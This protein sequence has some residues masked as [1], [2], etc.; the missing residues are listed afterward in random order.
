M[1]SKIHHL[2]YLY[3]PRIWIITAFLL[4][5]ASATAQETPP[6]GDFTVGSPIKNKLIDYPDLLTPFEE[7]GF[8]TIWQRADNY[9][10]SSLEH[11]NLIALNEY[12]SAE[13][14]FHYSTAYYSKWEAEIDAEAERVGFKH[15]DSLGNLI[16]SSSTWNGKSCWS[17]IGLSGPRDSLIYGPHYRQEKRYKRWLYGCISDSGCLTYTP[18][19]RM[20]LDNNGG[21]DS[22]E[23]V[24][25]IKVV[26]RYKEDSAPYNFHD[27]TFI[28]RTLKVG[29]FNLNGNFDD[30]YLHPDQSLGRYDYW[31]EFILPD[32]FMQ[33]V[34]SPLDLGYIDW[35]SF[36]GIQFWVDWLRTDS[37]C[38]LYIDYAEVYDNNGWNEYIDPLT[39]NDVMDS[40]KAYAESFS[41]WNNLIYWTGP[42]EPYTIDS[43]LPIHIVDSLIRSVQAPPLVV[44][45]DPSWHWTNK[46]NGEDEIEMF[47]SIAKPEK[48]ILGMYPASPNWSAI[49]AADYEW[50]RFNF[51]RTWVHD[52]NFW[53][54]P[55]AFG[56]WSN[57][58]WCV[59]RKPKSPELTS[60]V[61]LAL[62]HGSKGI[63]FEWFDSFPEYNLYEP[64]PNTYLKCLVDL[65]GNPEI[66][67]IDQDT[68]YNT[69]KNKLVPRLKDKLGKTL[70]SLNYSG[71]YLQYRYQIP[72]DN[73]EPVESNY[74]ILG[75]GTQAMDERNWHCGFF[76]R[77]THP[78]D[79]YFMLANLYLT[80]DSMTVRVKVTPPVPN[81][82]NYRFRNIEGYFDET[83]KTNII[84]DLTHLKGEGYLYQVA[85]VIQYGGKLIYPDT[86]ENGMILND[87]MIIENGAELTIDGTYFAKGNITIKSGGIINGSNGKIQFVDGKKLIIEGTGSITGTANSKLH[88]EFSDPINDDPTGILIKA[89]SSLTI[90]N[91][92]IENATTGINSL[93]NANYLNAQNVEFINCET[94][95][96][97]IAGRNP[98]MNPT[99]PP[100][101]TGCTMLNSNYGI[102]ISNLPGMLIIDNDIT[103]TTCGIY[104]SSVADAQVI[105]NTI[106]SN[107][108]EYPGMWIFSSGGAIRANYISGH[109]NGVHFANS[110]MVLG[111]NYITENKFHGLLIGDGSLPYMRQGQW[112]GIPPNM[113]ATSG[114]NKIFQNGG[115]EGEGD[116]NDGSEIYFVNSNAEMD[117]GCNSIY[118]D[119][120]PSPPLVNTELL[121]NCPDWSPIEVDAR[122]NYW[123]SWVDERRFGWLNVNYI[124]YSETPCPEPQDGSEGELVR[125]TSFGDV[126]D[127]V[128]A[129]DIEIPDLTETEEA[130][131]EAEEYFLTGNLTNALQIFEEIINSTASEEEKYPAYQRKYSIG[132]LTGQST[133]YFNQLSNTFATLSSNT[134]D[135]LNKKIL[136]QFSTL[137]KVGEQEYETAIGEFDG[138][139]QQNP[140]T[141]EAVYAEIDALTT[142]LLIE[143][144]DSTL[145]KGRLGKYLIKSSANYH[146]RVDEILRKNFGSGSKETEKELLPT[147][148][149]L[150]Q[151]YPNPFNPVTTIKYDL[152]NTSEVTLI[153]YDILGRKIKELVNT[154]QQAGRYEV[155]FDASNLA[156]GVYIYQLIA[157]NY[158]QSRKMILLK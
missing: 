66:S 103:N 117:K 104:L 27:I 3:Y 4:F 91:C 85:P 90:S 68:L 36:T 53:F 118:D 37:R 78:E 139:V 16:G 18:R 122:G 7:A 2:Y 40:I 137:S 99:P 135:T 17:S 120:E 146:Q 21:A 24:C 75:Y 49:R 143:E 33:S 92:K 13:Y 45:F 1:K 131:A 102:A 30:F 132:K 14:I 133:E 121:M 35:E 23:D 141:E 11:Y 157:E 145:Q 54:K 149:T 41:G 38:T 126:I 140:N 130:Y 158:I 128:Y 19:F 111:S 63:L 20:A 87:D 123:G 74:L 48:I 46:I 39:H 110:A 138:I 152:P 64:C 106:I 42:D 101:I 80:A 26:F 142:A 127:T 8:N 156:S 51:Q 60:M 154:K 84:K 94:H 71:D 151:N 144:A 31:P 10:Q 82:Q 25:R 56:L 124:P 67:E 119:R 93:V 69:V 136:S 22:T 114:Y 43:Y 15:R 125:M 89:N 98:G 134:Q 112:V 73:P 115:Y 72:T 59:W 95:S 88:L 113:Y 108:E 148:Y 29:D 62:A 96:I 58:A 107:R 61:M 28:E 32:N 147:E 55:Q 5:S 70:M 65:E 86:T 105:G 52:S 116:D 83:F 76:D 155:Q 79:K 12:T 97:N 100:Q 50:L 81:H 47:A 9:T 109:T 6:P 150:Y 153:I 44:H 34:D 77:P 57:D 129:V